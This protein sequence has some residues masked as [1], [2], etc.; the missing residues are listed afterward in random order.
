MAAVDAA[1]G[2]GV[3]E[4]A[5]WEL[6]LSRAMAR[7]HADAVDHFEAFEACETWEVRE[8]CDGAFEAP[9]TLPVSQEFPARLGIGSLD[10]SMANA[11]AH[12]GPARA[13]GG[14]AT[15]LHARPLL[16]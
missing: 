12:C 9:P 4:A 11:L 7:D 2:T 8:V 10:E 6:F 3:G 13:G 1:L 14:G 5:D 16:L 15:P